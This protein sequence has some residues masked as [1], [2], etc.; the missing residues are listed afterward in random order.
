M[1]S[2]VLCYN[3]RPVPPSHYLVGRSVSISGTPLFHLKNIDNDTLPVVGQGTKAIA[4]FE[5]PFKFDKILMFMFKC[6]QVHMYTIFWNS[7]RPR[8][9]PLEGKDH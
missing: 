5:V 3:R 4:I 1:H 6:I 9:S 7:R 8:L 2:L